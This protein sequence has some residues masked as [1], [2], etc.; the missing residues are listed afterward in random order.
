MADDLILFV[1]TAHKLEKSPFWQWASQSRG[2]SDMER[3]IAGE[4]LAHDGLGPESLDSFCLTLRLLIQ[5]QDGIS[6]RKIKALSTL[7]D[8]SY[9]TYREGIHLAIENLNCKLNE[10]SLV[11]FRPPQKTTNQDVFDIVFYG[12]IAHLNPGKRELFRDLKESGLFSFF[13]FQSFLG[14]LFHYRNCIQTIAFNIV[15]YLEAQTASASEK[16]RRLQ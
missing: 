5:D 16:A 9:T 10:R 6:I 11:Q 14:V 3:I 4:W 13:M 8:S 2:H 1:E 12:G 15:E 7:W